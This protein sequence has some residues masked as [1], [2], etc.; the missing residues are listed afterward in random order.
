MDSLHGT[1]DTNVK[2]HISYTSTQKLDE[3]G[4]WLP[5]EALVVRQQVLGKCRE[6]HGPGS[7]AAVGGRAASG[8]GPADCVVRRSFQSSSKQIAIS[9]SLAFCTLHDSQQRSVTFSSPQQPLTW[10]DG[11]S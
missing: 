3:G 8:A 2:F 10:R 5:W 7:A 1:P 4:E 9:F 11:D 6:G